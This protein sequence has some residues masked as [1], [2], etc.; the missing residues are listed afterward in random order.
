MTSDA[1]P[2]SRRFR[3]RPGKARNENPTTISI[4]CCCIT[5]L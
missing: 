3:I 5:A 1:I 2:T 4:V